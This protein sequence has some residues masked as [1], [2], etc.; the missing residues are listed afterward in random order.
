[1]KPNGNNFVIWGPNGSGKSAVVDAIDFLLTG[2]ILRLT[3]RGTGGI[4]LGK[5]GPNIDHEP[6]D[7]IVCAKIQ[8]P[9]LA[10]PIEIKRCLEHP[11]ILECSEAIRPQIEPI[12]T[13]ARQGQNVLTR[14]EIL[15]YI[16]VEP[17]AR[18]EQIQ[19][20]LNITE[21][22]DIRKAFVKVQND[23]EKELQSTSL[24]IETAKAAVNSTIQKDIFREDILLDI[25]NENRSILGGQ[26]VNSLDPKNLKLDLTL[27]TTISGNK[28]VNVALFDRDVANICDSLS[29]QTQ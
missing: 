15:K 26:P 23:F 5:H 22:A 13:L 21:I 27:P 4:T 3:G 25:I 1:M 6:K 28:P 14:R 2:R 7:A 8:I 18:A 20:L 19:A 29:E 16:T 9:N 10:E 12:M 11:N 24:S 17:S